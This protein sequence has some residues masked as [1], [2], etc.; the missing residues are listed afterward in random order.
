[1][2][3]TRVV[4]GRLVVTDEAGVADAGWTRVVDGR[5]VG[6]GVDRIDRT[7]SAATRSASCS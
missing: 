6:A 3:W 1:M 5:I 7:T 2:G 4:D